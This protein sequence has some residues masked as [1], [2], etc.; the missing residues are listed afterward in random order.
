MNQ[1]LLLLALFATAACSTAYRA[2][3]TPEPDSD[4]VRG[5][6]Q[7]A[8]DL[9]QELSALSAG[10]A[11]PDCS[12]ACDLVAQICELTD[13]IC[14]VSRR[15]PDDADL[16]GRCATSEQRCRRSRERTEPACSCQPR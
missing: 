3:R 13:R 10:A 12:R 9:E 1:K 11:A 14:A 2:A 4:L 5:Y 15:H 7:R 16:L 8:A 6:E